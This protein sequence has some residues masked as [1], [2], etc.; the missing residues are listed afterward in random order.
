VAAIS[1]G[2]AGLCGWLTFDISAGVAA[3]DAGR[4]SPGCTELATSG[5]FRSQDVVKVIGLLGFLPF[6]AGTLLGAPLVAREIE[7]RT[8][9][10]SWTLSVSRL[11]WLV[12]IAAPVI[13]VGGLSV[14]LAAAAGLL[15]V[16]AYAP[17]M[18]PWRTFEHF[19]LYGPVLVVRYA[20]VA[21]IGVLAGISLGRTLP[22][23]IASAS[24]ALA[25]FF[26]LNATTT[27]WLPPAELP[28]VD[29]PGAALG[30]LFVRQM[31]RMPDGQLLPFEEALAIDP[32]LDGVLESIEFG[33]TADRALDVTIREDAA[34]LAGAAIVTGAGI[35]LLR[36]RRPY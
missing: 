31:V 8:A 3:C 15:L 11:R 9:S 30:R 6:V 20:A 1:I 32:E 14:A 12:A 17:A 24:G 18:D 21:A 2:L 26:V 35:V 10:V 4:S 25:L 28:T 29:E 27:L 13:G 16:A 19:G 36:R 33:L 23:L 22:A 34:L 5:T 7:L